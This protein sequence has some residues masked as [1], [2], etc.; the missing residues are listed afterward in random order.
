MCDEDTERQTLATA[1]GLGCITLCSCGTV[2]LSVGGVSVRMELT[3]FVQ[4]A[5]MCRTAMEALKLQAQ[6]LQSDAR[7]NLSRMTH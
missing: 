2:S 1:P 6:A 7:N 5:E 4:T 3:A